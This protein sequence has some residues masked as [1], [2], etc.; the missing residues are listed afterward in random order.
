MANNL[1][2]NQFIEKLVNS[3]YKSSIY[4]MAEIIDNSVDANAKNI[5]ITFVEEQ[6]AEGGRG[7]K[8]ISDVFFIDNGSGMNLEQING[9]LRF[10]EGA[11][12]SN[13]RIGTFGVGLPNSSIY[14]G[15]RVEVYSKNKT[16][17]EWNFV[18][19]DLDEQTTRVDPGYDD[20]IPK[21]PTFKNIELKLDLDDASTIIRWSK[22]RNLG[23]RMPKTI[24]DKTKKLTGRLYR[25]AIN[26]DLNITFGSVLKGN[27]DYDIFENILPYDPLFLSTKKSYITKF[28]WEAATDPRKN[29]FNN[30]VPNNELFT[31][32]YHYK[33]F[34]ENCQEN[35]TNLPLFQKFDDYWNVP[36][37]IK[38]GGKTYSFTIRASFGY[39][40]LMYPGISKGGMTS[41]GKKIGEKMSGSK[42]F[43]CA[44]IFFIRTKREID[45]GNFGMYTVTDE[46]N[47][48]WTIEVEFDSELDKLMGVDY[49]KQHVDFRFVSN[50]EVNEIE[51]NDNIG[52]NEQQ[53]LLF[54]KISMEIS[55]CITK[56]R[57]FRRDYWS[58]YRGEEKEA[59]ALASDADDDS[60]AMP[61]AEPAVIR[62]MPQG[63]EWTDEQKTEL[64]NFLKNRFMHLSIE[65]ITLQVE[66]FASGM[67]KTIVLYHQNPT[68]NLFELT[69]VRGK[70]ITFINTE[71]VY[72]KNII[73]PLKENKNLSVFTIAI[74]MLIC[75]YAY[76]MEQMIQD[77]SD[78]EHILNSYLRKIS[79][80]LES[81]II[82]GSIKVDTEYWEEHITNTEDDY[83]D[84]QLG[85]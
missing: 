34:I 81:F 54:N 59:I 55:D 57:S 64:V 31:S 11:G 62:A 85:E 66:N 48:F 21:K 36:Y 82:N 69:T 43:Y 20:A 22:I 46:T 77:D 63:K 45:C 16:T 8:F 7:S 47:R 76:E 12:T 78:L 53:Q 70:K 75:S 41:L 61:I 3:G 72:Y 28:I 5:D 79:D 33:T 24:I 13:E 1:F 52:I 2:G 44:N 9:C 18:Y 32:S 25:Y 60:T 29:M 6:R 38:L 27:K 56:M 51:D 74:E 42:D 84:A 80:R 58:Q 4:A 23:S 83:E 14:V 26:D 35:E 67:N 39:K 15:R 73:D 65:S 68:G 40:S 49:Q 10:A 37:E 71:H 19:L 17:G 50:D 30:K